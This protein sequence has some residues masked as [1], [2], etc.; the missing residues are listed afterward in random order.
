MPCALARGHGLEVGDAATGEPVDVTHLRAFWLLGLAFAMMGLGHG[1][2]I[3][4]L[5][6]LLEERS[7]H[8][9]VAV[10]AAAMIGP[11]R[12]PKVPTSMPGMLCMP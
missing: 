4:H 3:P 7:I 1:A 2:L 9:E 8:G 10:L 11:A 5:L 6:P 12:M